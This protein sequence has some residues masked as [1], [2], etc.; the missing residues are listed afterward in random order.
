MTTASR[1]RPHKDSRSAAAALPPRFAD[2]FS[3]RGWAPHR[4]QLDMLEALWPLLEPGGRLLYATC[5]ILRQEND[6]V[7]QRFLARYPDAADVTGPAPLALGAVEFAG[8]GIQLLPGP[9]NTDGF[10]YALMERHA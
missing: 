5:S 7:V 1:T 3:G 9:A 10:Y 8:P 6:A 4:H 2:W